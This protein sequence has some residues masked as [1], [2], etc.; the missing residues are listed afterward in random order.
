MHKHRT[1]IKVLFCEIWHYNL[2]NNEKKTSE[3]AKKHPK[4]ILKLNYTQKF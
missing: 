4:F 3:F 2:R 1:I